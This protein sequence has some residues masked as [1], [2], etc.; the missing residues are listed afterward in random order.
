M[1]AIRE[2][3]ARMMFSGPGTQVNGLEAVPEG[4]WLADQRDNRAYL[5]DYTGR[6]L[7]SFA[8]P[9]RNASGLSY[10][11]GSVWVASNVRPA[12]IFRHDP[13]TGQ[14]LACLVLPG[15]GGVHG[16]Q[17]RPY[18]PGEQP[19]APAP[20]A[21]ELHPTAPAGALN[22]GPG[23]SGTLWVTRPGALRIDHL[24]AET[25]AMLGQIPFPASRSHG[26]FWHEE[27]DTLSVAET[28]E[29]HIFRL[30]PATG[31]VRDEWRVIGTEVHALTRDAEGH[32]WIGDASRNALLVVED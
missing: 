8:G 10:G 2:R 16:I 23:V 25:G 5:V 11:A 29:G 26:M 13:A 30:D 28:N 3:T 15:E 4:L 20:A 14:C 18:A 24:D 17:W 1:A 19:A 6:V 21:P 22:A 27:D 9:A 31:A 32:V 12:M 7:T